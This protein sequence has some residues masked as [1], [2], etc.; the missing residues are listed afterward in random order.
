[1]VGLFVFYIL[2]LQTLDNLLLS[3]SRLLWKKEKMRRLPQPYEVGCI[4]LIGRPDR[5]ELGLC[6]ECASD[7][8]LPSHFLLPQE[9][10]TRFYLT[11]TPSI[12]GVRRNP[13]FPLCRQEPFFLRKKIKHWAAQH[14]IG[15]FH[16]IRF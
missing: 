7:D 6:W 2:L 11:V 3:P 8:K 10:C 4:L 9:K 14:S 12:R 13:C 5:R 1:M 15:P 16:S